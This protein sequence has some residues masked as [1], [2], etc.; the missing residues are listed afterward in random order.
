MAEEIIGLKVELDTSGASAPMASLKSQIKEATNELV[1]FTGKF[2]STSKEAINAAKRVAELKDR[3]GDARQM[4]DAFNPDAKFNSLTQAIQGAAGAFSAVQGAM[5]LFGVESANTEKALLK[6]QSAM[7]FSQGLSNFLDGGIEGFRNL[8]RTISGPVIE[9]FTALKTA[10][11]SIGIGLLV[12]GLVVLIANWDKLKISIGGVTD[13]QR[14]LIDEQK[15]LNEAYKDSSVKNAANDVLQLK[16]NIGLAKDGVLSKDRVVKQYNETIGKTTGIVK[17]LDEAEQQLTKNG[18]KYVKMMLFKAA[19]NLALEEAAKFALEAENNRLKSL[20]EFENKFLDAPTQ[21]TT[22]E[23][24]KNYQKRI[25][26][27]RNLRRQEEVNS[28]QNAANKQLSIANDFMKKATDISSTMNF[29][30][31]GD[32]EEKKAT[33]TA[34]KKQGKTDIEIL[35]EKYATELLEA[36]KFHLTNEESE[37]DYQNKLLKITDKYL[38]TKL[39]TNVQANVEL[40]NAKENINKFFYNQDLEALKLNLEN[41]KL[42][43]AERRKLVLDDIKLTAE[44][45]KKLNK[46]IDEDEKKANEEHQKALADLNK[47]YD[48]EKLD[49][50]A[51]TA[52]KKEELDYQRRLTEINNLVATETEKFAIIEKLDAEHKARMIVAAKTDAE[53]Q[54]EIDKLVAEAKKEIQDSTL[55]VIE[56]GIQLISSLFGKSKAVQAAALIADS[57]VGIAKII[58]NTQAANAAVTAKYALIPA[59]AGPALIA[60]ETTLN[61]ISAGIGIAANVAA[62][63]KALSALNSSGTPSGASAGGT[64][65]NAPSATVF[66]TTTKLNKDSID[67]INDKAVKAYVVETDINNGQ[68]RIERILINTKFK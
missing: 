67:K 22:E 11:G 18:D 2:G 23:G 1:N 45:R 16:I 33:K 57:A 8:Y 41:E 12:T 25:T 63:A 7:A 44:D 30:L 20:D 51:D 21:I 24:Y 42:T 43:F 6:V 32:N 52:V 54:I 49:R 14:K 4:V 31:F 58:I 68:K 3:L 37:E 17:N 40:L 28:A 39:S 10:I 36:E 59:P 15:K 46:E 29:N 53:K 55:Q 50:L 48:D 65:P 13:E 61:K 27:Q 64:A 47:K 26:D 5:G 62:T 19:A 66:N 60:A 34:T 35:K 38:K 9:G 56:G